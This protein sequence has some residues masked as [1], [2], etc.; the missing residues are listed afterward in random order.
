[1]YRARYAQ[2][3]LK[4]FDMVDYK[5]VATLIETGMKLSTL[6]DSKPLDAILYRQLNSREFDLHYHYQ[7]GFELCRWHC[8]TIHGMCQRI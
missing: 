6:E 3:I 5:S 2:E 7:V 8:L 4:L 1:M